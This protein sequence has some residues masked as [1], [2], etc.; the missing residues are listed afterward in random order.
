MP[1]VTFLARSLGVGGAERQLLTLAR[2]LQERGRRVA[3]VTFYDE[4]PGLD[5]GDVKVV[6]A[7]KKGRYDLLGFKKRLRATIAATRPDVVHSYLVTPNIAS[8]LLKR[9]LHRPVVWDLRAADMD[10]SLYGPFERWTFSLTRRLASV[11]DRIV[12]NSSAGFEH[13]REHGYPQDKM[14]LIH[15]GIDTDYFAPDPQGRERMRRAWNVPAD[16]LLV[17]FVGRD[18]PTKDLATF[19]ATTRIV[20]SAMPSVSF[21]CVGI[22]KNGSSDDVVFL[23]PSS[24]MPAVYNAFD[25]LVSSSKSEGFPNVIAEAMAC[26]TPSIATDAGDSRNIIGDDSKIVGLGDA[27][28]LGDVLLAELQKGQEALAEEGS[29]GRRRIVENFSVETMVESYERVYREV[30]T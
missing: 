6:H 1:A 25:V 7:G 18:D 10:L 15:N 4:A 16:R 27:Q 14:V 8:A 20:R 28:E 2:S 17:G 9:S 19:L 22:T 11:P 5:T 21:A 13:H 30:I 24:D 29:N 26:G 12:V 23:G 3:I